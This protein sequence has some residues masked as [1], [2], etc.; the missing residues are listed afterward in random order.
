MVCCWSKRWQQQGQDGWIA[1]LTLVVVA[2]RR[3]KHRRVGFSAHPVPNLPGPQEQCRRQLELKPA[4]PASDYVRLACLTS[5]TLSSPS[6]W[7]TTTTSPNHEAP[8]PRHRSTAAVDCPGCEEAH[9][10]HL[11]Q[12]QRQ[13]AL[14]IRLLQARRQVLRTAHQGPSRL[15]CCRSSHSSGGKIRL[16][17]L[18]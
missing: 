2:G 7:T 6:H 3:D 11:R 10:H 15:L 1:V 8:L 14:A 9:R 13:A 16:W 18:Q 4:K 12:V 17:P 5:L